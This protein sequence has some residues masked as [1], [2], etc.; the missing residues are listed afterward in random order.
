[1]DFYTY[2]VRVVKTYCVET[3]LIFLTLKQ[4]T[5]RINSAVCCLLIVYIKN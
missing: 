5:E 3:N 1:M 2:L 4:T